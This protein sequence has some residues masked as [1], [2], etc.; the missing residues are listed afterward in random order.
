VGP[1]YNI[2][3]IVD[4]VGDG[5]AFASGLIYRLISA[6]SLKEALGFALAASCLKHSISEDFSRIHVEEVMKL[7]AGEATGRVER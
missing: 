4:R 2:S 6:M 3:D 5:D 7:I 1:Y